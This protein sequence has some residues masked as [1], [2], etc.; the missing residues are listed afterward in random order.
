MSFLF[1][2]H[3]QYGL[4]IVILLMIFIRLLKM[5]QEHRRDMD[6]STLRL[7]KLLQNPLR[8]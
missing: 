5:K 7:K 2:P 1:L 4:P 8:K 6:L 3:V